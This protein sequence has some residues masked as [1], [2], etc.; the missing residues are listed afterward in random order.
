MSNLGEFYTYSSKKS[1]LSNVMV[2]W[3]FESYQHCKTTVLPDGCRDIIVQEFT[4]RDGEWFVT[5]LSRSAYQVSTSDD[6][7]MRGIRLRAGVQIQHRELEL[8]LRAKNPSDIFDSDQLD[9]FCVLSENLYIALDCLAAGKRSVL[10]VA[11]E[12]GVSLRTLERLVKSGTGESPHFWLSLA[13]VRKAG[14]SLM[15]TRSLVDAAA[16]AEYADQSHM[17]REIK[18]W[19]GCTPLQLKMNSETLAVL[20]EPGYGEC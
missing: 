2:E 17:N 18:K 7:K 5:D 9:E 8:W 19:F 4:D 1:L 15:T 16:D 13:R 14:R 3:K 6:V 11:Q 12:L 10:C 20:A